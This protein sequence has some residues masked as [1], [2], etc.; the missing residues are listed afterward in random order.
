MLTLPHP[1]F[2]PP[3]PTDDTILGTPATMRLACGATMAASCRYKKPLPHGE[4]GLP[5]PFLSISC[6]P[7]V[8]DLTRHFFWPW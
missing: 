8:R 4:G 7:S 5:F 1:S 3:R 2:T 6:P